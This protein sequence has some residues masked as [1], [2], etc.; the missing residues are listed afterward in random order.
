MSCVPVYCQPGLLDVDGCGLPVPV[1]VVDFPPIAW[2][3]VICHGLEVPGLSVDGGC[4]LSGP[5]SVFP[6]IPWVPVI[7]QGNPGVPLGCELLGG[8]LLL[9]DGEVPS[10]GFCAV[11]PD[12]LDGPGA[13]VGPVL[14]DPTGPATFGAL[15]LAPGEDS[16]G[17]F[18]AEGIPG[19]AGKLAVG[20]SESSAGDGAT[21]M[22]V[23]GC[24]NPPSGELIGPRAWSMAPTR[25]A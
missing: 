13:D 25:A 14:G 16:G 21:E 3:P 24:E 1:S 6:P 5:V 9:P 2:V 22:G 20:P 11:G 18:G 23:V 17:E 12:G 8:E 19:P 15:G 4:E 7:C 10:G